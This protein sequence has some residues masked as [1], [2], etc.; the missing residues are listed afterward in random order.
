MFFSTVGETKPWAKQMTLQVITNEWQGGMIGGMF[1]AHARLAQ[2]PP[3]Y[4]GAIARVLATLFSSSQLPGFVILIIMVFNEVSA[5][6]TSF[7]ESGFASP[8]KGLSAVLTD[9]YAPT[10]SHGFQIHIIFMRWLKTSQSQGLSLEQLY[11]KP[12]NEMRASLPLGSDFRAELE[13]GDS[14]KEVNSQ[15]LLE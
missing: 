4:P 7:T 3:L 10:I 11:R 12:G 15:L 8:V 14:G 2:L 13:W 9:G 1:C 6:A 5:Q